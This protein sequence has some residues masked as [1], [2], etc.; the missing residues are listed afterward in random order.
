MYSKWLFRS[1]KARV[2][3]VW[4]TSFR[5]VKALSAVSYSKVLEQFVLLLMLRLI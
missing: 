3:A 2:G 1:G 4:R 5:S